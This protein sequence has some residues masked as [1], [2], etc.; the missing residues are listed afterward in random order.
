MY[1]KLIH[2]GLQKKTKHNYVDEQKI[3]I[4]KRAIGIAETKQEGI[5]GW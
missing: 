1:T 5:V 3:E 2:T 4:F